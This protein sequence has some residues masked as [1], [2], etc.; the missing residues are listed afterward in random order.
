[1]LNDN[2]LLE[3]PLKYLSELG[4]DFPAQEAAILR[5]AKLA[6]ENKFKNL[7]G[8]RGKKRFYFT[9]E[10]LAKATKFTEKQLIQKVHYG[11]LKIHDLKSLALFILQNL[12]R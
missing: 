5:L 1:M 3:D 9:Y 6:T 11:T 7:R 10:D 4:D 2:T 8:K 12:R